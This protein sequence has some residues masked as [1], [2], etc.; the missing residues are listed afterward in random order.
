[1]DTKQTVLDV[2][3]EVSGVGVD[4][5]KP[6]T[7]LVSQLGIDSPKALEMLVELEDRL[8]VEIGDD[9]VAK[10]KTVGDI[11]QAIEASSAA[12]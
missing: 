5:M 11:L 7:E 4:Q 1:M 12:G 10:M 3:A 6:E 9:A 8:D 2:I